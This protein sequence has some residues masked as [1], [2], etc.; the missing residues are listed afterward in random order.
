M[1]KLFIKYLAPLLAISLIPILFTG[2]L[3]IFL[4]NRNFKSLENKLG[5][6]VST[7][8]TNEI[9]SKDE[10]IAKAESRYVEQEIDR[11]GNKLSAISLAPAFLRTDINLID[12]YMENI[13]RTEPSILDITVVDAWG[14]I[15][16]EKVNSVS[17]GG[18]ELSQF[19][20]DEVYKAL[21]EKEPYVSNVNISSRTQQ[22]FVTLGQPIVELSGNFKGGIIV[23]LNLFFIS[24][25]PTD[26]PGILYIVS[27]DGQ[28]I[29]HPSSQELNQNSD[30]SKYDYIQE[31]LQKQS[32]TII[33]ND[34]LISF[35]TNKYNW[36]TII[37]APTEQVLAPVAQNRSS[38]QLFIQGTISSVSI[39]IGIILLLVIIVASLSS[40]Y[41]TKRV[42]NPILDLTAA[43][44]QLSAGEKIGIIP[45]KTSDE[46]GELTDAF[47]KM[48]L[49][50]R[51][52]QDELVKTNEYI[53]Q[54]AE[55]LLERYNSDLEQFAYVTTHDLIEPLRMITSYV[56]LLQRRYKDVYDNDAKDFMNYIVE[57]VERMHR[58]INDLFE[59]SHI[60]TNVKDFEPVDTNEVFEAVLKKLDKEI[61]QSNAIV[62]HGK[63]PMIKGVR[64]NIA[65]LFQNLVANAIKFR[66]KDSVMKIDVQA[67]ERATEW[68]FSV[69]DTGIGM[70]PSYR[71]KIFEIFKRLH[72]RDEYPGSGM[73][74]AISKNI[75]E[76]HGGKIWVESQLGEGA[77]FFFTIKKY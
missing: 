27:Q 26:K 59:Y 13:V 1:N 44:R 71:D 57:G 64:S 21:R 62:T 36:T 45:R 18:D 38:M 70:D 49:E 72:K 50:L 68:L 37:E 42:I 51:K 10:F 67:E 47:N 22:P 34:N 29:A 74:L 55:E 76:R 2:A 46:V 19:S 20:K 7:A 52:K 75:V 23:N 32:G 66:K 54:Q 14:D 25:I 48:A 69:R 35:H 40:I 77:T 61:G 5:K 33:H 43:S 17:V 3:V 4:L 58:I 9:S 41:I 31:I 28:L 39:S 53:T 11:I 56:Q 60:R 12:E 30:Y 63:L 65:Q 73:G 6:Q 16:F 15:I 24:N 8:L